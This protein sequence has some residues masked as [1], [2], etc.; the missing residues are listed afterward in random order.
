MIKESTTAS[1]SL[2]KYA[3]HR[4]SVY[5]TKNPP[6]ERKPIGQFFT[7][8]TI[9]DYMATLIPSIPRTVRIL[10]PGAGVGILA[11]ALCQRIATLRQQRDIEI[12]AYELDSKIVPALRKVMKKAEGAMNAAGHTFT[13]KILNE[14]FIL[15]GA[16]D[17][18]Q[19]Q[20]FG[21]AIERGQ[22]DIV[23]M[24][25]P[26]FKIPKTSRYAEAMDS[27]IHG[28][29]NIY[30]L[31][32]ALG[33]SLLHENGHL[34]SITPR[35]FCNGLYFK[36]FRTWLLKHFSI[37]HLHLFESRND[38][39][40]KDNVLQENIITVARKHHEQ[41]AEV[42][43][44]TS[45]GRDTKQGLTKRTVHSPMVLSNKCTERII[46]VPTSSLDDEIINITD[47]WKQRFQDYG[48]GISTGPVVMFRAR[49]YLISEPNGA[50]YAPLISAYN[51][52]PYRTRW[53]VRKR[54]KP[55]AFSVCDGSKN[56][57]SP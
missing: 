39:F 20:L 35:S 9:A 55:L 38:S 46:R 43:I 25:P 56:S 37:T 18:T 57:C 24:N 21:T 15:Y 31:F 10:D 1:T 27:I 13:A 32:M 54:S 50:S 22:F 41:T 48:L 52:R 45:Y 12:V 47:K 8:V 3:E 53:P 33:G 29:P 51:V 42:K 34:V 40:S 7:P 44:S 26:Y 17:F 36:E 14:D 6:E 16:T 28:Q 19:P 4:Q 23:I 30:A 2:T 5:E 49:D 11:A